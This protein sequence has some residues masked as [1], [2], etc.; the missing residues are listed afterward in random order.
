MKEMQGNSF[1]WRLFSVTSPC[2]LINF[3]KSMMFPIN[4]IDEKLDLLARTFGC[5]KCSLPFTY[6]WL[7]LGLTKPSVQ[8]F[9]PLVNKCERRLAGTS[10]FLSQARR[11]QITNAVLT[12]LPTFFM[13]TLA[14]P[15]AVIKLIDKF[16]SN[17]SGEVQTLM[18]EIPLK[19]L[20]RWCV[21]PR[22]KEA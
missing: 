7:P 22:R 4:V 19:L 17:A 12:S 6:Y 18:Q 11:L 8:D 5:S 16:R 2:Q 14:L 20:G 15:K 1:L 13:C 21:Y 9:L 10:M 3:S